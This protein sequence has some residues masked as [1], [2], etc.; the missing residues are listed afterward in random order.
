MKILLNYVSLKQAK[1]II[2]KGSGN[3]QKSIIARIQ[4]KILT[5]QVDKMNEI[6]NVA[7]K[8]MKT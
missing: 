6:I 8:T 3:S 5:W 1:T 7:M 2:S 4:N